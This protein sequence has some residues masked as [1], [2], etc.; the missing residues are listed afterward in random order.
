MRKWKVNENYFEKIDSD[1]KA[2]WLG[3]MCADGN[4]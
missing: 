4:V 2:Y 1:D 3:F